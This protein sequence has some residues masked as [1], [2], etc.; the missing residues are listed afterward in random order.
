M[1]NKIQWEFGK[2]LNFVDNTKWYLHKAETVLENDTNKML[3]E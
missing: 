2:W 1:G 3:W